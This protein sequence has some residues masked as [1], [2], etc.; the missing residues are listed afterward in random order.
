MEKNSDKIMM[1]IDK[2]R[3]RTAAA[4]GVSLRT[5]DRVY[6]E[7]QATG[8]HIYYTINTHTHTNIY[9]YCPGQFNTHL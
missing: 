6:L 9:I 4:L 3:E 5:V 2:P 1:T 8:V 7:S